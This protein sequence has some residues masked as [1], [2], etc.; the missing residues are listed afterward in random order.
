M[1]SKVLALQMVVVSMANSAAIFSQA[2]SLFD[3]VRGI[4][5]WRY[6]MADDRQI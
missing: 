6:R 4:A 1:S 3:A 5:L 2:D